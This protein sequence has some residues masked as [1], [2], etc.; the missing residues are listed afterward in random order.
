MERYAVPVLA[1][2]DTRALV[3]H[4]RDAWRDARRDFDASRSD[5]DAL[6]AKARSIPQ[7]GRDRSGEGGVDQ[8]DLRIEWAIRGI[9]HDDPLADAVIWCQGRT[10]RRKHACG[11]V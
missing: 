11:G 7:D 9:E 5:A 8:G 6:V 10:M 3:R 4:L 1:E 2:I